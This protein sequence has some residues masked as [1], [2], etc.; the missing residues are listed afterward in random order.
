M[1]KRKFAWPKGWLKRR[2]LLKHGLT[3]STKDCIISVGLFAAA[4]VLCLLLRQV[5]P[6]NDTRYVAMIFLLEVFLTAMFT[7]GYLFSVVSAIL[8]VT[9]VDYV[10]TAPYWHVSFLITGFPLTF[11]VMLFIST[12]TGM[13]AS[14]AKR[15]ESVLRE[16]ER[17][18][19]YANLL[20][21]VSHDIRT[22]LTSIVGSSNLLLE[23][24][25]E[26][27]KEQRRELV[28]NTSEE[29]QWLI[30]VVEN[31][32]SITR[33]GAENAKVEKSE[34]PAEE[35]I[36]GAVAKFHRRHPEIRTHVEVPQ[37]L[38]M[39]PMDPLLMQQVLTNILEN[40][41]IHGGST[42]DIVICLERKNADWASVSIT[43]NGQGIPEEKLA[44]LFE[45]LGSSESDGD[46]HRNMG[47]G[48]S[49]CR[50]VVEAHGGRIS[51]RNI[52][53]SGACFRIELPLKEETYEN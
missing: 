10:F 51:A 30:R 4:V 28:R 2:G 32:L 44:G 52:P 25:E 11:L 38:L 37:E 26:L 20:R 5:D 45:G 31:M 6:G 34:E 23:H 16:A 47:I 15:V 7:D 48:L 8:S 53:G 21:S 49:V 50:T 9:A 3:F 40:A 46:N 13:V 29:A 33:L 27:S 12:A 1:Q 14:R 22:P 39:V 41:A 36:E 19:V 24:G 42:T 18:K 17:Q 35:I 43:D